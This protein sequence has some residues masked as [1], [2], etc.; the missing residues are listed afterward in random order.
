MSWFYLLH[1]HCSTG[2]HVSKQ[3]LKLKSFSAEKKNK[4]LP[5]ISPYAVII[6]DR[7]AFFSKLISKRMNYTAFL[8]IV[9]IVCFKYDLKEHFR[10]LA[11]V[12]F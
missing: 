4:L 5:L 3:S 12:K 8:V 6:L 1:R 9:G 10:A 11:C 7:I 2:R